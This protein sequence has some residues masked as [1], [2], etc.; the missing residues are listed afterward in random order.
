MQTVSRG[1]ALE[2]LGPYHVCTRK[3]FKCVACRIR[4]EFARVQNG[5]EASG[6]RELARFR[7]KTEVRGVKGGASSL[8]LRPS[9]GHCGLCCARRT[10]RE[11]TLEMSTVYQG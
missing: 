2:G 9:V 8:S 1:E 5:L 11:V 4:L 6:S 10:M 3:S 7:H